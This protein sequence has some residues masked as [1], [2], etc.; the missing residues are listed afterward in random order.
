MPDNATAKVTA[1]SR[2]SQSAANPAKNRVKKSSGKFSDHSFFTRF[3]SPRKIKL[4][5]LKCPPLKYVI[6]IIQIYYLTWPNEFTRTN[7]VK[8]CANAACVITLVESDFKA[9]NEP[10]KMNNIHPTNS[11]DNLLIKL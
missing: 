3:T 10:I 6:Y 2:F 11:A 7:I 9:D 1:K 8:P 4:P 5:G